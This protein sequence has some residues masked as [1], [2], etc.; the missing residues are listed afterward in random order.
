MLYVISYCKG[1]KD[2]LC[3]CLSYD[4][5]HITQSYKPEDHNLDTSLLKV[6][7]FSDVTSCSLV[8][9]HQHF[10]VLCCLHF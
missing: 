2:L 3:G 4:S 1:S 10:G 9:T 6:M 5:F 7:V 8:D